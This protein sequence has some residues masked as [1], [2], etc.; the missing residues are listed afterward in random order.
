M[1]ERNMSL[2]KV[3]GNTYLNPHC[4]GKLTLKVTFDTA[5]RTNL[6][7]V[8]D[9]TGQQELARLETTVST[10]PDN[11]DKQSVQ[12]DNFYH[13]EIVRALNEADDARDFGKDV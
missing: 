7:I 3:F 1:K 4:V 5:S 11:A 6:T 13:S 10:A 9:A 8:Y 2:I 12:R